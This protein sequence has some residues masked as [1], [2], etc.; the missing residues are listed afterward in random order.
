MEKTLP[1][2]KNVHL[3]NFDYT[4]TNVMYFITICTHNKIRYFKKPEIAKYIADEIHYRSR[5]ADEVTVL[6]YCIMPDHVH[7]EAALA[8]QFLRTHCPEG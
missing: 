2:R 3:A 5:I 4:D 6:A 7:R 1:K 8:G